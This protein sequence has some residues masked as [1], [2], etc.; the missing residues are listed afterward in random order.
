LLVSECS[1]CTR[2]CEPFVRFRKP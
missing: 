2:S 1:V